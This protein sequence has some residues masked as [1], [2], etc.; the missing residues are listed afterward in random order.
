VP[1]CEFSENDGHFRGRF[2]TQTLG[3][4]G[5][6]NSHCFETEKPKMAERWIRAEY[7]LK[8]SVRA[9]L[10]SDTASYSVFKM[11]SRE[12]RMWMNTQYNLTGDN[13]M[14]KINYRTITQDTVYLAASN[15]SDG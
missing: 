15:I 11:I 10:N 7:I 2:E 1:A 3:P 12:H 5:S 9:I 4:A 6:K 13:S 14:P 8:K